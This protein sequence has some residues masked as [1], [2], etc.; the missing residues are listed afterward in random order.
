V[1]SYY[2]LGWVSC[3][4]LC[5][6]VCSRNV[7]CICRPPTWPSLPSSLLRFVWSCS[8][9]RCIFVLAL[10]LLCGLLALGSLGDL[11]PHSRVSCLG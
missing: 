9:L 3:S 7:C 6:S 10:C 8:P 5:L 11:L 1:A 2:S 4:Q